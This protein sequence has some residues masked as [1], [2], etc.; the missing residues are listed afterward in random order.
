[1]GIVGNQAVGPVQGKAGKQAL[2]GAQRDREVVD[3]R[4]RVNVLLPALKKS[5]C[6]AEPAQLLA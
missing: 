2:R 1:V 3:D 4:L 5:S 6:E